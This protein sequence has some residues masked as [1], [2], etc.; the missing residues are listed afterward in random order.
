[1]RYARS[2]GAIIVTLACSVPVRGEPEPAKLTDKDIEEAKRVVK[3]FVAAAS[4]GK[5]DEQAKAILDLLP[6]DKEI[7]VAFPKHSKKVKEYYGLIREAI[8]K[9]SKLGRKDDREVTEVVVEDAR[10]SWAKL[11][12]T[13]RKLLTVMS[14][15]IQIIDPEVKRKTSMGSAPPFMRVNGRWVLLLEVDD[16]IQNLK[17]P[18]DLAP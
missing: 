5:K 8:P 7:E 17:L 10:V 14:P 4:S 18:D 16:L 12:A 11:K 6:T 1:M 13:E 9:S 2:I 15:S 3:A